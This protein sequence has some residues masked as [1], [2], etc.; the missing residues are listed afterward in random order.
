MTSEHEKK[1]YQGKIVV[2]TKPSDEPDEKA[3]EEEQHT[4]DYAEV[5]RNL[6]IE[7]LK[8]D[9]THDGWFKLIDT[10]F[11]LEISLQNQRV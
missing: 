9:H 2:I 7:Q 5:K 11:L 1:P 8:P 4:E 10:I 3:A 6:E